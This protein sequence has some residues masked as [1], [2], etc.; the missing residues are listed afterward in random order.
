[1]I[2]PIS[3]NTDWRVLKNLNSYVGY[4]GDQQGLGENWY[5]VKEHKNSK[6]KMLWIISISDA[7]LKQ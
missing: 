1:M 4:Q 7:T 2:L 3:F 5:H 6:R